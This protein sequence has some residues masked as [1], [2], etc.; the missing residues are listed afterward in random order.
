M[1][2]R[3]Q[4]GVVYY[5]EQWDSARWEADIKQMREA[6]VTVVRLAEFAW[7]R[8]EPAPEKYTFDWLDEVIGLFAQNDIAVILCTPTNTPPRWLTDQH[9]DVLPINASGMTTHAGVRGHRC[10]NSI[11][12]KYYAASIINQMAIRYGSHPGV[13][14]WQIDNEFWMLD[15]HCPRCN[16][17]FRQWLIQKYETVSKL[18]E[19]WGTIVWSGEYSDWQQVT[20]PYGGSRF[21]N[22]SYLLDFAR[23]Q[24]DMM[25]LFLTEQ[26]NTIRQYSKQQ[27][28]T[29][30]FHTYPPRLNLHQLGRALDVAS[31]DYYP[32]TDPHKQT[33]GPY[34]GAL[35]LDV[36]RGIKRKNFY[37]ME[38]LSGAPGCWFPSWR[39]PYP[40]FI[41]AFTWQAI[42]K[43]ADK[44]LHFRWRSATI[45]AEQFWQGLIDP[46]NV[47]G[48][49]FLEF[50]QLAQEVNRL[51]PKLIDT[52]FQHQVAILMSH[53]NMEA[54]RIQY[55][56]DGFDYYENIKDYHRILT[57]LGVGCDVI[58]VGAPL[59]QYKLV[60]VPSLYVV[61]EETANRLE[62]F[63]QA[64]GTVLL[65][66]RSGVKM[67]NNHH[68]ETMLPGYLQKSSGIYVEEY[69]AIGQSTQ[70]IRDE[71]GETYTASIWC[72]IVSLQGA[73]A[74][75][76]Y[77]DEF[78]SGTPAITCNRVGKGK[79]YYVATHPDEAYLRKLITRLAK[80]QHIKYD[81]NL[82][83]GVQII[84]R[85]NESNKYLFIM[86]LSRV[87]VT[88]PLESPGYSLLSAE[89]REKKIELAPYELDILE[90]PLSSG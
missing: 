72:D 86:N 74:I 25:E 10:F 79:V 81:A 6:G 17:T 21:Q 63:A 56:S 1:I 71:D 9:P 53:E 47:P 49:R 27:F 84:E 44:V 8:M 69:D 45:G 88:V 11:S 22:P 15:C 40:G 32:N 65:T 50:S 29:H 48:R 62:Q 54:M 37:I 64:G 73:E 75:A 4:V 18:N 60:I 20:V 19:A 2:D 83:D 66:F 55:Q 7:C 5:P 13:I 3:M 24:W 52:T 39:A 80:E 82:P 85:F 33:T 26:I 68:I 77:Q 67:E 90:I 31:F 89:K 12:L 87:D 23:F 70:A 30:N 28:I 78:Y 16:T 76:W 35:S 34:S 61:N 14:G 36:T 41:R 51:S 43:G 38:Q 46:S 59:D 58:E 42:A 57:K